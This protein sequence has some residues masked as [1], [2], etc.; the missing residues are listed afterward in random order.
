MLGEI[1]FGVIRKN[2][3]QEKMRIQTFSDYGQKHGDLKF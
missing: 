2:F 1:M 3:L